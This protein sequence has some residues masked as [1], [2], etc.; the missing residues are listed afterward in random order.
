VQDFK[1]NHQIKFLSKSEILPNFSFVLRPK[2]R[3]EGGFWG[4]EAGIGIPSG[5][6]GNKQEILKKQI[7]N[8]K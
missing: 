7:M 4:F 2:A 1:D 6:G 5:S 8:I 3:N